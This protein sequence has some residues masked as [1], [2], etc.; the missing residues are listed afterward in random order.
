MTQRGRPPKPTEV[1]RRT[2]NPG[3]RALPVE[4]S[5][6]PLPPARQAPVC[7]DDFGT[8]AQRLWD[9][10]WNAAITWLSP[11]SDI[12]AV[13]Q[14]CR[15][16]DDLAIARARYRK[17]LAPD[18]GRLVATFQ[19]ELN[20]ALSSLGFDPASRT[21]LGVAEVTRVSKLQKLQE[22]HRG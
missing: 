17:S 12:E 21:R 8:D 2:G 22:R 1:K 10:A 7:P 5:V 4:G 3:K 20:S 9:R 13:E 11:H 16:A 15:L 19:K 18:D 14:A 6:V